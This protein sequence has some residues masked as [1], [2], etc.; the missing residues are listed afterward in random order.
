[1]IILGISGGLGHDPAACLVRDGQLIAMAEEERFLRIKHAPDVLPASAVLY[2]L[3][4]AGISMCDVD[5]VAIGWDPR[6]MNPALNGPKLREM[7]LETLKHLEFHDIDI[8]IFIPVSHHLAHAA[9]S[10]YGS[11]FDDAAII[12]V[13]GTGERVATTLAIGRGQSIEILATFETAQSLGYFYEAITKYIG[14]G[15]YDAVGKTMGL[16]P[17]GKVIHAFPNIKLT[18]DGYSMGIK[19]KK[20]ANDIVTRHRH[21]MAQWMKYL[22]IVFGPP[23]PVFPS[24]DPRRGLATRTYDLY[25]RQKNIAASAQK[26]IERVLLHLAE[27]VMRA[28]GS[29]NLVLGGGV[30]LNCTANGMLRSCGQV[31]RMYIFPAAHDSGSALGAALEVAAQH[32]EPRC[33]PIDHAYWG[34]SY[35]ERAITE[36]IRRYGLI[37]T[38]HADIGATTADLI[39]QGAIVGWFQGRMEVGPRALGH[40]SILADPTRAENLDRV[41]RVKGREYWRPL[42]PSMLESAAS[43]LLESAH[44]S[45]F[46]LQASQVRSE[47][48][49]TIPAVT[50][51][52]GSTRPQT[53]VEATSPH[54]HALL[55]AMQDRVGVGVVLN[56]SFNG[57]AEPIVC[58]PAHALRTFFSSELDVLVMGQTLVTKPNWTASKGLQLL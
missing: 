28:T 40:R 46:M 47:A 52:D 56:T 17:Y 26:A 2:C 21:I 43:Q 23:N 11:G 4:E 19:D 50:H 9:A 51:V 5:A 34:P 8:P 24:F 22:E 29:R 31:D 58:T 20:G 3:Q 42:A 55:R 25:E 6:I 37:A 57:P 49:S 35:D 45:P 14:L 15:G 1:M 12:I 48:Q 54:Y 32:G 36:V 30:A 39:A 44:A 16:A 13:D 27:L 53:V 33:A 38:D 41:N 18:G 10:F 7:F